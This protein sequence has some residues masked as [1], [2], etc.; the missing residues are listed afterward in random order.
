MNNVY[1]KRRNDLELAVLEAFHS[2]QYMPLGDIKNQHLT[3]L[4]DKDNRVYV[5]FIDPLYSKKFIE[6]FDLESFINGYVVGVVNEQCVNFGR[7]YSITVCRVVSKNKKFIP[8]YKK[9]E[10]LGVIRKS[11]E[12]Y[13]A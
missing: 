13:V 12:S 2:G 11:D 8:V 10:S 4:I 1:T 6:S 9:S 5:R 7:D 3:A